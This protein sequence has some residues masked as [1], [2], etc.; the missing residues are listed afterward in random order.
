MAP[1]VLTAWCHIIVAIVHLLVVR[2][3]H[4]FCTFVDAREGLFT[5]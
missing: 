3:K 1:V 2:S 5:F 4:F